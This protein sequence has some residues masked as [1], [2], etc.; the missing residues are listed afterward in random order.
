MYYL[1]D[2]YFVIFGASPEFAVRYVA[3]DNT[4]SISPIACTRTRG[5]D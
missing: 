3:Q 5:I 2:P 1:C 4:V